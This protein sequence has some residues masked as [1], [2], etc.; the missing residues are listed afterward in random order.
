MPP[1]GSATSS[2]LDTSQRETLTSEASLTCG[3]ATW[4]DTSKPISSPGS[5]AGPTRSGSLDG[6]TTDLFGQEVAPA[7]R[8]APPERVRRP[9]TN[10]TCGLRGFLSSPSAALQSSLESRLRRLLD[11]AGSTLFSLTWKAKATPAGRPYFQLAASA[12]RISDN[13]FG[14]W[15][16]PMAGTPAQKGYNEAG[17]TDSGRKTVD[18]CHW[19]TPDTMMGP[20][21][22]R[23]V[24]SNPQHQSAKGLEA[25]ALSAWPTPR[26]VTGGAESGQRKQELGRTESGGGDLQAVALMAAWHSPAASDGNG[27][28]RPHPDTTMTGQHPSGRK[29]NM[30]LASQVHIGLIATGSPAP[31]E[32]RGQLNPAH[33]RWLQGYPAEWDACAPTAMRSSR[34]SPPSSSEPQA[35]R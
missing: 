33:S 17:N 26:T 18:L 29:V 24:S 3:P 14:S 13:A 11:G 16:S 25:I 31:T 34:K 27:G 1:N 23:G 35:K 10:A 19:P 2:P 4:R 15:P 6:P 20:H 9:M 8:S 5:A 32:K 7:S 12:L 21:G 22:P 30:G 28:K